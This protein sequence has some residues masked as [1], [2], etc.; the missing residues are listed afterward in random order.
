MAAG[1]FLSGEKDGLGTK[2]F[3]LYQRLMLPLPT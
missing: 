3:T 1:Q 2:F